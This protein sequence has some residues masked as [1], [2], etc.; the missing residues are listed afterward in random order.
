MINN[1]GNSEQI[2]IRQRIILYTDRYFMIG[3]D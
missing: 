3:E 1:K 2:L